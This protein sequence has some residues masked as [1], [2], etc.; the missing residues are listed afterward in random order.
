MLFHRR[1]R[2]GGPIHISV[3]CVYVCVFCLFHLSVLR[4][5]SSSFRSQSSWRKICP[6]DFAERK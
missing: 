2:H 6:P 1:G 4:G 5:E 3:I